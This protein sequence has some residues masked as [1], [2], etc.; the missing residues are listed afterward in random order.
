MKKYE[1]NESLVKADKVMSIMF[2]SGTLVC[3]ILA[4]IRIF[5]IENHSSS[6][7]MNIVQSIFTIF[8]LVAAGWCL[9]RRINPYTL[10][11]R[12]WNKQL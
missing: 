3:G 2:I 7:I 12:R 1:N 10:V 9:G 11:S 6:M 4:M 8:M 5:L